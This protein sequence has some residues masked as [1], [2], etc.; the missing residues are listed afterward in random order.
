M[1]K[2]SIGLDAS[3]PRIHM[4][5]AVGLKPLLK[6]RVKCRC[7]LLPDPNNEPASMKIISEKTLCKNTF[8]YGGRRFYIPTDIKF[9]RM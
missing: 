5:P 3:F 4:D 7:I 9:G 6:S 8:L 2:I 1:D